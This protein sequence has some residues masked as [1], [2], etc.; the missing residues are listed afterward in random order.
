MIK[1]K[2]SKKK[3]EDWDGTRQKQKE[4]ELKS[5]KMSPFE[6]SDT[7]EDTL[8]LTKTLIGALSIMPLG[9]EGQMKEQ[10]NSD[11]SEFFKI[12]SINIYMT[13][14]SDFLTNRIFC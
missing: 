8:Q 9:E 12:N 6:N 10:Y 4:Q 7:K 11:N 5:N 1:N 14:W 2:R 13:L 3:E